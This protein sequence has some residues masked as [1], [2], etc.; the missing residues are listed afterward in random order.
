MNEKEI[1]E[2]NIHEVYYILL[3]E[4]NLYTS[5]EIAMLEQ[6]KKELDI[7]YKEEEYIEEVKNRPLEFKCPKCDGINKSSNV[8]CEY[9]GYIFKREDY[10]NNED[11]SEKNSNIFLYII[12]FLLP[13][14]GIIL[15][16][17]YISKDN[18]ELGKKLILFSIIIFIVFFFIFYSL[19]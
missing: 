2:L 11:V 19:L 10:F 7:K 12:S 5:K 14:V 9:C 6:R 1:K 16:I 3:N 13:I 15:G 17:V 8:K 4:K 18:E